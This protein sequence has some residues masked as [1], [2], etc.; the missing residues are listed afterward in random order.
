MEVETAGDVPLHIQIKTLMRDGKYFGCVFLLIDFTQERKMARTLLR[1]ERRPAYLYIAF[2]ALVV[3]YFGAFYFAKDF[4]HAVEQAASRELGYKKLPAPFKAINGLVFSPILAALSIYFRKVWRDERL[5]RHCHYLGVPFDLS[6]VI[7]ICTANY[8]E[9]VPPAL[10]DRM[11]VIE[12]PG[13]T[14]AEKLLIAKKYLVPRQLKEHGV[15]ANA[16]FEVGM[17]SEP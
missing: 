1:S 14:Q 13:Y 12:I 6:R 4:M 8:M 3:S 7:F 11:E 9:P 10:R 2:G 5:A 15:T 16:R 17:A